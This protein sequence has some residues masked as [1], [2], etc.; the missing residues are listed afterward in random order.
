VVK[1]IGGVVGKITDTGEGGVI[2]ES[3]GDELEVVFE[4]EVFGLLVDHLLVATDTTN[5]HLK[6]DH[7]VKDEVPI[8][9]TDEDH[10]TL[11]GTL[12]DVDVVN[13]LVFFV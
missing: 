1:S 8:I 10:I 6:T 9:V 12:L 11:D 3:S 4:G 13:G 5:S 2:T 7:H